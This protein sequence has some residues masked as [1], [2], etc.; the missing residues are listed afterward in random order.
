MDTQAHTSSLQG[1]VIRPGV[2]IRHGCGS[3]ALAAPHLVL[4]LDADDGH[5]YAGSRTSL[6]MVTVPQG[7]GG[8]RPIA[9]NA[10]GRWADRRLLSCGRAI[11]M[12]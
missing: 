2:R 9:G 7:G 5:G 3:P 6:G 12:V 8:T 4:Y 1:G 10:A 11:V